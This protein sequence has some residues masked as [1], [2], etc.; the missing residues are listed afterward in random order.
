MKLD[1]LAIGAHPDDVEL[2]C[3]ATLAKEIH[4]GKKVGILDLTRGE[5]GTRGSAE[6]RDRE[7][8]EAAKVLGVAFRLN[9]ELADGFLLMIRSHSWR[10]SR[11][12][13]ST[14]QT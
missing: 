12:S 3:A 14:N 11:S 1:I 2:G 9:L 6:I 13:E 7:A 10:S 5:L 8:A 4:H